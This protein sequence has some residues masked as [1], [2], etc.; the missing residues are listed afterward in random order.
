MICINLK[1]YSES[2][3]KNLYKILDQVDKLVEEKPGYKELFG[4]APISYQLEAVANKYPNINFM[5]QYSEAIEMGAFTGH[6]P[7]GALND[8]GVQYVIL[9]HSEKRIYD[10]K[11]NET[12]EFI[13]SKGI[14][15]VVC[16]E[17]IDEAKYLIN[18]KP[19]AIAYETKELIGSGKSVSTENP[20]IVAEFVELVKGKAK[21][22]IGAGITTAEDIIKGNELGAE[23]YL[24]A[25]AFV[26]ADNHY[27][28]LVEFLEA[29]TTF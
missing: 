16:C 24:L 27:N 4:V 19:F 25:S 6:L 20:E 28:K 15:V 21:A 22:F 23:G 7:T 5:A 12:I 3:G 29:Y 2:V 18:S 17:S 8:I 26:K 10:N 1:T 14:K 11:I 9:N 13:Q